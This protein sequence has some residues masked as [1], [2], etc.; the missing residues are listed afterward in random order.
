MLA[1]AAGRAADA[2]L[3]LHAAVAYAL[4]HNSAIA[5]RRATVAQDNATFVRLRAA[6]LPSITGMLQSQLDRSQNQN[7]S[8]AQFGISPASEFS[9][10]TA[11]IGSTWNIYTGSSAQ[12]QAQEAKRT[13]EG[14]QLDLQRAEQQLASDIATAFYNL[15]AR[16]ETVRLDQGDRAYQ[17]ELLDAARAQERDGRIAEVDV[18]RAQVNTLRSD[19][20]L[21]TAQNDE[22][23]AREALAQQIGAPP[24]TTF[25]A[26][27][28]PEPALPAT[29]LAAMVATARDHRSDVLSARAALAYARLTLANTDTDL[30]PQVQ[31]TG[32]FGSQYSPTTVPYS[33][34]TVLPTGVRG[35]PGFWTLGATAN[36]HRADHRL[37]HAR[38]RAPFRSRLDRREPAGADHRGKRRRGRRPLGVA[39]CAD[40]V[41]QP[42]DLEASRRA[43]RRVVAH[44]ATAVPQRLDLA[45]RCHRS[46][47]IRAAS[48]QRSHRSPRQLRFGRRAPARLDRSGRSPHCR[49]RRSIVKRRNIL[50]AAGAVV[51]V[52]LIGA[53]AGRPRSSAMAARLQTVAYGTFQTRLPETGTLQR[54]HSQ[55][56]SAL[57]GGNL[58]RFT[59]APGTH[60][61]AGTVV[62]VIANPQIVNAADTAHATYLAAAARS[63]TA[64]ENNAV[65]PL[66]N[67]SAV[68]Q[69][70]AALEQARFN[71]NQAKQ[72][73]LSGSQSGLGYG[74]TSSGEQ[75]AVP[76]H[77]S[78]TRKRKRASRSASTP[79]TRISTRT[80]R[81]RA[82]VWSSRKRSTNRIR[83]TSN[84]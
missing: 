67:Q 34:V 19:V 83:S 28:I 40:G 25:A 69:A 79:R 46:G 50:I 61:A 2:P 82:T 37:R 38:R 39:R 75:R 36:L 57:V 15:A 7:G 58:D 65:L 1:P 49:G 6:E 23:D 30:F 14:A 20:T 24:D 44:R 71:L 31:I 54:P 60:V 27:P 21:A 47:T 43:R 73:V 62:A 32:S 55:T 74:G 66:Q 81:S 45:D 41:R 11:Q 80:R 17:G 10:N 63:E 13:L 56:L 72:D 3:T 53:F 78:P 70:Q 51:A 84:K 9:Q 42:A 35:S 29:P 48:R 26:G 76:T 16:R 4:D 52:I 33:P 64:N 18:L 77:K 5:A 22:A 8:L 68:V 12:I 59:V